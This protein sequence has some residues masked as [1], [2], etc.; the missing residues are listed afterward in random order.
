MKEVTD[1]FL[2]WQMRNADAKADRT[3]RPWDRRRDLMLSSIPYLDSTLARLRLTP[4]RLERIVREADAGDPREQ[5]QLFDAMLE[6][7]TRFAAH[8]QTRRLAVL[9]C[10][11]KIE[12][13]KEP[14]LAEEITEM[15][16]K[17]DL[18]KA[19][20]GLMRAVGTGYAGVVADWAPGGSLVRGFKPVAAD[21][22]TFDDAGYP[23][24]MD[25]TA[26]GVPL[27][28]YH[29]A[30][31]LYVQADG[32]AGLPCQCGLL[33]S[34]LWL[35][36]FKNAGFR[37]WAVFLERF[38]IPFIL[39]KIP[40]GDFK[41]PKLRDELLRS[42]MNVRNGGGGVGTTETD[43][44]MLNGA[45]SGNQQ[46]FEAFQRYCDETATLLILGQLASSDHAGGLSAGTAQDEVRQ[47]LLQ[48]DCALVE[49][50]VQKL[51]DWYCILRY[52][53]PDAGDL[54]FRIDCQK[55]EDMTARAQRDAQVAQAAGM[56]L[57]KQYAEETYGVRLEEAPQPPPAPQGLDQLGFSDGPRP[58]T[59]LTAAER[60]VQSIA[61]NAIARL[62]ETD[63]LEAWRAPIDAAIRKHFGDVDPEGLDDRQLL[64][65]FA[66]RAPAF[67]AS[68][69]GVMDAIDDRELTRA[70]GESMLAGYLDG[71]MPPGFWKRRPLPAEPE[72]AK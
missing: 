52:G 62:V 2:S 7:E 33:R 40:S 56:R 61:E 59:R 37:D 67:L 53:R 17:A 23:A 35:Y 14:Q 18:R 63:A 47:D 4:S 12:S 65:A 64:A 6:K 69:P 29:P 46:A 16:R 43:M 55:P 28:S 30:Q 34:L 57:S 50:Q 42:I 71:L 66:E 72:G 70:L 58:A 36:L 60:R 10:P 26:F 19:I 51:V 25:D 3:P 1:T 20:G 13:S 21:R 41:D 27:S 68:L 45:S 5:A 15:L 44:Q 24:V 11:W 22:W 38:G 8:L 32:T 48:A 49:P 54:R 39:G 31:I 9:S